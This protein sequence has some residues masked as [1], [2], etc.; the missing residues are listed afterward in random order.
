M[1]IRTSTSLRNKNVGMRAR[2]HAMAVGNTISFNASSS[3]I[4]DSGSGFGDFL[5]GDIVSVLGSTSNNTEFT[6]TVATAGALTITPAPTNESA[7]AYIAIAAGNGGSVAD[8]MRNGKLQFRSGS[9]ATTADAAAAGT[10]LIEFTKDG[11]TF[12]PGS[13]DNGINLDP[14]SVVSGV[15][16]KDSSETWKGTCLASGTL[17]HFRFLANATDSGAEST[18]HD[19]IDGSI[20]VSSGDA[21][22]ASTSVT[23]GKVYYLNDMSLDLAYQYGA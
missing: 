8:V 21:R 13:P 3:Q 15:V 20:G 7:G 14:D 19:R 23:A 18:T 16:S 6:V 22:V 9:Q 4:L 5:V 17:G 10:L 12:T 11:G 1:A 2:I